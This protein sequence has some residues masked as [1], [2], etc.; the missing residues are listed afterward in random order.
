[1]LLDEADGVSTWNGIGD[2]A[3]SLYTPRFPFEAESPVPVPYES[4]LV[5]LLG[6]LLDDDLLSLIH[7]TSAWLPRLELLFDLYD[8][9][10]VFERVEFVETASGERF[11]RLELDADE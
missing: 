3:I 7:L 4:S 5:S 9:D 10:D 2:G 6:W 1:M 11:L 8:L